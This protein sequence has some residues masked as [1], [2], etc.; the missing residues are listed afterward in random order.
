MG[1]LGLG[2]IVEKCGV[3]VVVRSYRMVV[4]VS[5]YNLHLKNYYCCNLRL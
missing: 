1:K 4:I 5:Y 2:D 3:A